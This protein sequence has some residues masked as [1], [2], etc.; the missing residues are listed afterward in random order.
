ML[1]MFDSD[2][3]MDRS[4]LS[5]QDMNCNLAAVSKQPKGIMKEVKE[6]VR[7]ARKFNDTVVRPQALEMDRKIH[8]DPDYLP[9]EWVKA[10]NE[11]GFYTLWIPKMFG[12]KGYSFSSMAYF[13][14]ELASCCLGMANLISVHY[15]GLAT[16]TATWNLP[17]A[18]KL[19]K[20]AVEGEKSGVP[21][22]F[23]F[24]ITEPAAGT[25][26]A[27][28][29]LVDKGSVALQAV[30]VE[31]GY[32]VNGTKIFISN[33]HFSTWHIVMGYEDL[34]RPADTFIFFALKSDTKGFSLGRKEKKM[35]QKACPASEL[36]F[37]DCFVPDDQVC[38]DARQTRGMSRSHREIYQIIFDSI[39]SSSKAGVCA[40]SAG[41]ARGVYE[42]TLEHT[43]NTRVGGSLMMNLEWVQARLA[44]M[45]RN[46][47][48]TRLLYS[49]VNFANG[50]YGLNKMLQ[51][52]P[53]YY[54]YKYLPA[55]LVAKISAPIVNS[56]LCL[57]LTRKIQL[58][59]KKD[60]ELQRTTGWASIAKFTG[61]DAAMENCRIGLDLMGQEGLRN[62]NAIEKF[63]RDSKL[64]Q[65]YEGTNELNRLEAFK[66]V[67]GRNRFEITMF[68][69]R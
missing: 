66:C 29:H 24:A 52:K 63:L 68:E 17:L 60:E 28:T 10:A 41:V 62:E 46:V 12:G 19:C 11:F 47:A 3:L 64:L 45:L 65:I 61:S 31:G 22:L 34:K 57:W 50:M 43:A 59:W 25:D 8:R 13:A 67:I 14:E 54:L 18:L 40:F 69:D 37:H 5:F 21:C 16:L 4:G 1:N 42:K 30:R 2:R 49:E 53:A 26:I 6:V 35:G 9:W 23:D 58:D 48:V 51:V 7:L 32:T 44:D 33:G 27:D 56:S 36:I 55:P 15:L 39:C 38:I 20:E